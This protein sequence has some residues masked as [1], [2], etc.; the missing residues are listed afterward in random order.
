[1]KKELVFTLT[2][3]FTF[4]I[5][6]ISFVLSHTPDK[7]YLNPIYVDVLVLIAGIFLIIDSYINLKRTNKVDTYFYSIIFKTTIGTAIITIHLYQ[8]LFDLI[9]NIKFI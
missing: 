1:M 4:L 8:F 3:F 7:I 5:T 2:I 9:R 6:S